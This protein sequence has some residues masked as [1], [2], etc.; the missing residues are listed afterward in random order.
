MTSAID[1]ERVFEWRLSTLLELGFAAELAEDLA[2]A[3]REVDLGEVRR[4]L[5]HGATPDQAARIL[6]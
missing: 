6:L 3:S 2:R 4:L 1:D 5:A